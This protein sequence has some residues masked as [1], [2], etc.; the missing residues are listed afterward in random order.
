M[1]T[2]Y[3][4][5]KGINEISMDLNLYSL[6]SGCPLNEPQLNVYLDIIANEKWDSYHIPIFMEISKEHNRDFVHEA[7]DEIINVHPILGMCVSDELEVPYLIKGSPC[8][9]LMESDIDEEFILDFLN[10]PFDLNKNLCRF[11]IVENED[12]YSLFAVFHHIIFDALSESVFKKDLQSILNG[13]SLD[14]DDS[15]L[16]AS[17]FAEQIKDTPEYTEARD[18]YEKHLADI[19]EVGILLDSISPNGPGMLQLDLDIDIGLLHSSLEN[20]KVSENVLFIS[21]FAYTLS[22]FVGNDKVLFN[23]TENGRDRFQN[24]NSIGMYVNTLP[25]QLNCENKDIGSFMNYVSSATYDV[26]KYNYYP[27]RLLANE[28]NVESNL[29]FQFLP[30]WISVDDCNDDAMNFEDM[31]N[32]EKNN[33]TD[34]TVEV[35][36]TKD[37]YTLRITYSDKYSREFI[38]SF[39]SSYNLIIDGMLKHKGL[40]EINYI[41]NEDLEKLN[42]YNDTE[43][44]LSHKDVLDAFNDNLSRYPENNFVSTE[45][46]VYTYEEGAFISHKI[47]EKLIELGVKS[48]DCVAYLTERSEYYM[49]ST[50]AIM[51]IGAI[52]VP[53]DD[54]HPDNR[55]NFILSDTKAMVLIV[56]D[57]TY[58]RGK[59]I[60]DDAIIFNIS[61]LVNESIGTLSNLPVAYVNIA[62]MLYTSGTTGIPKGVRITRKSIINL[63]TS[64]QDKYGISKEDIYGLY[65]SIGFDAAL[66]ALAVVL[67]SGAC[68]TIIPSDVKLDMNKMN[69]YFIRHNVT[70]TLITTQVGKLFMQTVDKTSLKVLCVGGEKLGEFQ[71][72]ENYKLIDMYG[73][74]ETCVYITSILNKDKIDPTSIGSLGYNTK[75]Y[76]LDNEFRRVPIGAVGELF[77]AGHQVSDGYLNRDEE[78]EKAFLENAFE[79]DDEYKLMYRTADMVRIL[80]DGTIGI[81]GRKDS[82]VKIRGNRVELSEIESAIH[83]IDCIYDATVQTIK[84]GSNNELVAYVVA[85]REIDNIK[86]YVC[87]HVAENKPEYMVPSFVIELDKIPLTVNGKVDR[88]SLPAV[89][90][91]DLHADYLAPRNEIE[92]RIVESYE[93][94]FNHERI[95][96]NDDFI[97]LGGDSLSAIKLMPYLSDYNV[98][99]ADILRLKTPAAIANSINENNLELDLDK[100]SLDSPCPLNEPQLNVYL[101][102]ITQNKFDSYFIPF[103]MT[104]PKENSPEKIADALDAILEAHPILSRCISNEFGVPSLVKSSKP[105]IQIESEIEDESIIAFLTAPFDLYHSLCRFLIVEKEDNNLL[106]AVFH[107]IVFDAL[108]NNV[109]KR[110]LLSIL[111][112]KSV[113]TDDS[114]LKV[115]AFNQEIEKTKEY[116]EANDFFEA[117]LADSDD[118]GVLLDSVAS[119]GAGIAK[120]NLDLNYDSFQSFLTENRIS[121]NILFTSVFAYTLSRFVGND[122]VLFNIIENGRDRFNNFNAIGMFVNTLPLLVNCQDQDIKSFMKDMSGLIYDT[123]RYNFYPFRLLANEYDITANIPSRMGLQ[124]RRL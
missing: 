48:Q 67:Y 29:I 26:M 83:E 78:N 51:S 1:R 22:R 7:L 39:A 63:V 10:K 3:A 43:H 38:E 53:L 124:I 36:Q 121:E 25:I 65:A 79:D 114:F 96:V 57:E 64:Y 11:L 37:K 100:F 68:L 61:E 46:R 35:V 2:P 72:P 94:V 21:V 70:Q 33:I 105:S 119:E 18:F 87:N 73:P 41:S 81:V 42:E 86:D 55:I 111:E 122:N 104:L 77:I 31:G 34:L 49:F 82:Q 92:K 118:I 98:T 110:D 75:V 69:E 71:S 120:I 103:T 89:D 101:D 80:P 112:G 19:D 4:I 106:Y 8:P 60:R 44:P 123:M 24:L 32:S 62:C 97:R 14:V 88:R 116:R 113:E 102:I 45:N 59:N 27:F 30:D 50:L 56:S 91:D 12:N 52:Y 6:E 90:M 16:K 15:F 9:I 93:E 117:M 54:M 23:I 5:A 47:A 13:E 108:S 58:E 40:S 85:S 99:V 76:V 107:H 95:S 74:T 20:Y 109:F 115:A 66:L 84:N 28:F 17:A